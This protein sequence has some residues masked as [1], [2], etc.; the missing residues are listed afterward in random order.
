MNVRVEV[1]ILTFG[2]PGESLKGS[3]GSVSAPL[4]YVCIHLRLPA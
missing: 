1:N 2:S 4:R 3:P